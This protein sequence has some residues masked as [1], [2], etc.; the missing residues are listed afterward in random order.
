VFY[1]STLHGIFNS[2]LLDLSHIGGP[3]IHLKDSW[4]YLGFIFDRK[5]IFH[6]HIKFYANKALSTIK[7]LGNSTCGLLSYQKCLLYRTYVFPIALYSFRITIECHYL[8]CLI[9][10]TNYNRELHYGFLVHST[11]HQL[12]E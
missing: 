8:A 1:F 6:Q 3:I 9:S 12:W 7:M 5:L 10:L 2:P 4:K 11:L